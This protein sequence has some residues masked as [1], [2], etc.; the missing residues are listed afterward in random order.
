MHSNFGT[1]IVLVLLSMTAC[2]A[3]VG[4]DEAVGK[5]IWIVWHTTVS[6][7]GTRKVK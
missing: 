2:Q 6:E 5:E 3:H 7:D 4:A 1:L